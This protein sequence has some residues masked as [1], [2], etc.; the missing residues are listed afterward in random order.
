MLTP[1]HAVTRTTHLGV[2]PH[3]LSDKE[4]YLL[5]DYHPTFGVSAGIS[6]GVTLIFLE[7]MG[8]LNSRTFVSHTVMSDEANLRSP[9]GSGEGHR[10]HGY[11]PSR[12]EESR[13][14]LL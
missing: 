14:H 5:R 13:R 10:D 11:Q 7:R 2:S 12:H 4:I 8:F 1:E 9:S 6:V 3:L